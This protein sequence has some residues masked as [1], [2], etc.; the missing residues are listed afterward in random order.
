MTWESF[1]K[2]MD[3]KKLPLYVLANEKGG[4]TF[5]YSEKEWKEFK[6][7]YMKKRRKEL[8]EEAKVSGEEASEISEE[9]ILSEVKEFSE[10]PKL[11]AIL[12]KFEEVGFDATQEVTAIQQAKP[13]YRVR[14]KEGDRDV[15]TLDEMVKAIK[16]VGKQGSNIQ[17]YKGLGEMNPQQL[18]ETTMD[19]S[20]RRMLQVKL[21]DAVE[22]ENIF[23]TLMG[24][25]VEP[26]RIFIETHALDVQ[27]LDI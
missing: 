15:K 2:A 11:L 9:E 22:A 10:I 24:D 12:K 5:I 14:N 7:D 23:S 8:M 26:R 13:L 27:N 21:D 18:W 16:E 20:N 19:P 17:R 3:A 1:I 6:P 4:H 25:K